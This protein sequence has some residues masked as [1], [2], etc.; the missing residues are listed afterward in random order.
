[1]SMMW[2]GV[3]SRQVAA[4]VPPASRA[5]DNVPP[6]TLP[7]PVNPLPPQQPPQGNAEMSRNA[8][9]SQN[10]VPTDSSRVPPTANPSTPAQ[11]RRDAETPSADSKKQESRPVKRPPRPAGASPFLVI[12]HFSAYVGTDKPSVAAPRALAEVPWVYPETVVVDEKSATIS[13]PSYNVA[14]RLDLTQQALARAGFTI[15]S[16]TTGPRAGVEEMRPTGQR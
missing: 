9:P 11:S 3:L 8:G 10:P 15:D 5:R 13:I 4:N 7:R 6:P 1:V 14:N 2:H 12:Y 16:A